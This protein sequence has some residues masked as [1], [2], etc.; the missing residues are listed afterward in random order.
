MNSHHCEI[1]FFI[2]HPA[3]HRCFF[4]TLRKMG[5]MAHSACHRVQQNPPRPKHP[6][7]PHAPALPPSLP[8]ASPP[9]DHSENASPAPPTPSPSPPASSRGHSLPSL[10]LCV[11]FISPP[12][13]WNL[14]GSC[15]PHVLVQLCTLRIYRALGN[16]PPQEIFL[17]PANLSSKKCLPA[18]ESFSR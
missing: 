6:H 17:K 14:F 12:L 16:C 4:Q 8:G 5:I 7:Q 1:L 9:V 10:C 13:L 11:W 2:A 15:P 3:L 18:A